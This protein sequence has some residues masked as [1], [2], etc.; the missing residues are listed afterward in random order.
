MKESIFYKIFVKN[1]LQEKN[2]MKKQDFLLKNL[3]KKID[4]EYLL[5]YIDLIIDIKS[6][7]GRE[8]SMSE[9]MAYCLLNNYDN[10]LEELFKTQTF[11]NKR[12]YSKNQKFIVFIYLYYLKIKGV[13]DKNEEILK[14]KC[15]Y[16]TKTK[17]LDRDFKKNNKFHYKKIKKIKEHKKKDYDT[18]NFEIM[19]E[20][21]AI[22]VESIQTLYMNLIIHRKTNKFMMNELEKC[23]KYLSQN[24]IMKNKKFYLYEEE[25]EKITKIINFW[26][27]VGSIIAFILSLLLMFYNLIIVWIK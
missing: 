9:I 22:I 1:K 10:Y 17:N 14:Q 18:K 4:N 11:L 2:S 20:N 12:R 26:T 13:L 16:K 3:K 6:T 24:F 25:I 21:F 19:Y 27:Q 15:F 8:E 7:F 23:N 5:L